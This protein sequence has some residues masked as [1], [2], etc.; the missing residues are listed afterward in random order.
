M[1]NKNEI[2]RYLP[3]RN[4][5]MET[6]RRNERNKINC[7]IKEKQRYIEVNKNAMFRIKRSDAVSFDSEYCKRQIQKLTKNN[8]QMEDYIVEL[9]DRLTKLN[10]GELDQE[11]ME[12]TK[13]VMEEVNAKG[14]ATNR[15]K[16]VDALERKIK[17]E[18]YQKYYQENR[19]NERKADEREMNRCYKHFLRACNSVPNYMLK[20][21]A[22]MPNNK[23]YIWKDVWCFG[24]L[25]TEKGKPTVIFERPSRDVLRIREYMKNEVKIY[26][27][28][29]K[30]RKVLISRYEV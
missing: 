22:D 10:V 7:V 16:A 14:A 11:L 23:G 8:Q 5:T 29:G 28:E 27:K 19:T 21:L 9:N 13:Q 24:E 4:L 12:E 17:S 1:Q 15:R 20:N 25:P 30:N 18:Q 26:E 3:I 2:R 6:K